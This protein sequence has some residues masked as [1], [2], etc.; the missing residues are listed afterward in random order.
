MRVLVCGGREYHNLG[1]V[2][3]VLDAIHALEPITLVIHGGAPGADTC[4][5]EWARRNTLPL[6]RHPPDWQK[7]GRAAGPIRNTAMLRYKPAFVVAFPGGA[8]TADMIRQAEAAGIPVR[9]EEP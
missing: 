3:S 2:F 9:R 8:G 1:H 5:D 4:A 7:H 6:L